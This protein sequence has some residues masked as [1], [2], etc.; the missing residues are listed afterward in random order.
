MCDDIYKLIINV[1]PNKVCGTGKIPGRN[2]KNGAKL[3]TE[4]LC[5]IINLSLSSKFNLMCRELR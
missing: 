5:K 2:I 4:P 1:D 3:L